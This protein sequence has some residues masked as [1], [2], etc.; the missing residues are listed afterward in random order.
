MR[1]EGRF[2]ERRPLINQR[3]KAAPNS[4]PLKKKVRS[5]DNFSLL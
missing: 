5:G 4:E 2:I 1:K 3:K